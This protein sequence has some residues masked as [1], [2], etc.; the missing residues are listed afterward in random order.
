MMRKNVKILALSMAIA[1]A[2][3]AMAE[4]SSPF[5]ITIEGQE[6]ASTEM[7]RMLNIVGRIIESDEFDKLNQTQKEWLFDEWYIIAHNGS[8]VD[9]AKKREYANRLKYQLQRPEISRIALLEGVDSRDLRN[10]PLPGMKMFDEDRRLVSQASMIFDLAEYKTLV[11]AQKAWFKAA[12]EKASENVREPKDWPATYAGL[13]AELNRYDMKPLAKKV[14]IEVKSDY[15]EPIWAWEL[16]D[17]I[18]LAQKVMADEL[19][20]KMPA[21][22]KSELEK[23]TSEASKV[24]NTYDEK[25]VTA[26]TAALNKAL[27]YDHIK[28]VVGKVTDVQVMETMDYTSVSKETLAGLEKAIADQELAINTALNLLTNYPKTIAGKEEKLIDQ[29]F[30]A[31]RLRIHAGEFYSKA[32]GK[33]IKDVPI[34]IPDRYKDLVR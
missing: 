8:E 28:P 9:D 24:A 13:M 19:Y 3:P 34:N 7:Y 30:T 21:N 1:M 27:S 2:A 20:A 6:D 15:N 23:A 5:R 26:A 32:T 17:K 10:Q 16:K 29:L 11:P 18:I 4:A 33:Q 25:K 14:G 31:Q 22:I 12:F